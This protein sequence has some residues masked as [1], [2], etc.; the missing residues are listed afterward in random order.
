MINYCYTAKV[1]HSKLYINLLEYCYHL[2]PKVTEVVKQ[3]PQWHFICCTL[4]QLL[5]YTIKFGITSASIIQWTQHLPLYVCFVIH[6]SNFVCTI[7]GHTNT[8]TLQVLELVT[9]KI[10]LIPEKAMLL[11]RHI[12]Y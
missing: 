11:A 2:A 5:P 1:T 9:Y 6:Y 4:A 7:T 8:N 10:F 3:L 12:L